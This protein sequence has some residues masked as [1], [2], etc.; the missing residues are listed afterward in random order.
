MEHVHVDADID[1][2]PFDVSAVAGESD[3]DGVVRRRRRGIVSR[4][5][6]Q[7]SALRGDGQ[8]GGIAPTFRSAH[9]GDDEGRGQHDGACFQV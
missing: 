3:G 6:A 2:E 5:D 8:P 1:H 7:Q 9:A 4:R